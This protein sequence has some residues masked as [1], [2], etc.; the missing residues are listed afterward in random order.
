MITLK[1]N[2]RIVYAGKAVLRTP[3]GKP[4]PAVPQYRI[5]PVDE[6]DP[7]CI[8]ELKDNERLIMAGKVNDMKS[9]RER[10]AAKIAGRELP[11]WV[12]DTSLYFIV[13]AE[14]INPKTGLT[15]EDEE[16][17]K[18][19]AKDLANT[20]AMEMRK[21]KALERQGIGIADLHEGIRTHEIDKRRID[22]DER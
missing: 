6:T 14:N 4:L 16:A 3:D 2:E 13:D 17:C 20:F 22:L 5:V 10:Y 19:L 11:P 8:V 1:D 7:A 18:E 9:A 21:I 12:V 15:Y